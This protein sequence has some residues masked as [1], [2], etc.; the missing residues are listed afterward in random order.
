MQPLNMISF[1]YRD[2]K[3]KKKKK[4][5]KKIAYPGSWY[6][7]KK[8]KKKTNKQNKQTKNIDLM[9]LVQRMNFLQD[10]FQ[11]TTIALPSINHYC[12]NG[13]H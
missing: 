1:Y 3:L 11:M 9:S 4:K 5:K 2:K 7:I 6:D 13:L 8:N 12:I 10:V